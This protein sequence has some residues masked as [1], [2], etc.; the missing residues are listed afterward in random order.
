MYKS[1]TREGGDMH[2]FTYRFR[3]EKVKHKQMICLIINLTGEGNLVIQT[4]Y[5]IKK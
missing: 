3:R 2:I 5:F 4:Y 1:F